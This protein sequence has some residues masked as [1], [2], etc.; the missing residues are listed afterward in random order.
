M[1]EKLVAEVDK[2]KK[3]NIVDRKKIESLIYE[4]KKATDTQQELNDVNMIV[5]NNL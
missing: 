1:N 5:N 4:L 3:I 2:R